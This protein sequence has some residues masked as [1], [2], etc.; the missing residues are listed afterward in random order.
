MIYEGNDEILRSICQKIEDSL[1][2]SMF[3]SIISP[4]TTIKYFNNK[5]YIR[6]FTFPV[7]NYLTIKEKNY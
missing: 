1:S 3:T 4:I 5:L 7:T 2:L 6:R